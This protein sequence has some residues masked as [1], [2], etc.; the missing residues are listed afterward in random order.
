VKKSSEMRIGEEKW[1]DLKWATEGSVQGELLHIKL[2][3]A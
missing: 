2:R 1:E 3:K